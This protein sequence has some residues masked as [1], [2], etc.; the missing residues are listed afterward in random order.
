M[1]AFPF[2][3]QHRPGL[4]ACVEGSNIALGVDMYEG[5][6]ARR[7]KALRKRQDLLWLVVN[8]HEECDHSK[9]PGGKPD[10][11]KYLDRAFGRLKF[12]LVMA[13]AKP[14]WILAFAGRRRI[15]ART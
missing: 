2:V 12:A 14:K 1:H 8:Q 4:A 10:A 5:V 13:Q 11:Q 7:L 6:R 9:S 15:V 3:D